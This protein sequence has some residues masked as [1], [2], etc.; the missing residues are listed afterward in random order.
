[1]NNF[2]NTALSAT[3]QPAVTRI[4]SRN[5]GGQLCPGPGQATSTHRPGDTIPF[6]Q[7]HDPDKSTIKHYS[8]GKYPPISEQQ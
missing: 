6:I 4:Y 8:L 7:S 2:C 3:A 1:M 5:D